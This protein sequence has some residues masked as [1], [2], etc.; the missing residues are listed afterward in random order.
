MVHPLIPA[1]LFAFIF[2]WSTFFLA[3]RIESPH[4][5]PAPLYLF[6]VAVTLLLAFGPLVLLAVT[7]VVSRRRHERDGDGPTG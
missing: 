1:L 7:V 5:S 6:V 3:N 4:A 2:R